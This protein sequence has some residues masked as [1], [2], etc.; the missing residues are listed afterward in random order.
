MPRV[1]ST[2]Q[3]KSLSLLSIVQQLYP[4]CRLGFWLTSL[5]LGEEQVE[6]VAE[7]AR[8]AGLAVARRV[9]DVGGCERVTPAKIIL[10]KPE[11][12]P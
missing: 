5:E 1:P 10:Q 7:A 3:E 6:S 4:T 8:C 9:R 2:G 12:F 11:L